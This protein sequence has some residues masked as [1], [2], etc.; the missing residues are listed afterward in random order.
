MTV[1][2]DNL[3]T[4]DDLAKRWGLKPYTIK[5]MRRRGEGPPAVRFSERLIRYRE[6]DVIAY[7]RDVLKKAMM[8]KRE[9]ASQ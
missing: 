7:E 6:A 3:L 2:L 5:A 9:R 1:N 8:E 4:P